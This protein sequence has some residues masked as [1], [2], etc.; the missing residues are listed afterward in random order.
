MDLSV[1]LNLFYYGITG[2]IL[3]FY[4]AHSSAP[5][6]KSALC[7]PIIMSLVFSGIFFYGAYLMPTLRNDVF[8]I[9]D[10]LELATAPDLGILTI[11][12]LAFASF[13]LVVAVSLGI[14]IWRAA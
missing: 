12:L 14:V 2:A 13:L 9:R 7:L 3:S 4:F 1:K 6:V 11:V 8:V 5:L 10:K